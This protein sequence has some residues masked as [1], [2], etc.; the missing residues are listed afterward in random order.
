MAKRTNNSNNT[1]DFKI[2]SVIILK[3]S[4]PKFLKTLRPGSYSFY[5]KGVSSDFFAHN[6]NISA[7]VGKNGAGKSSL[8]DII[9][10]MINNF[11]A[12]LVGNSMKR[13]NSDVIYYIP[14]IY[15]EL[16]YQ[17]GDKKGVLY[18]YGNVV[19]LSFGES[20]YLLSDREQ[21]KNSRFDDFVDCY[22]PTASKRREIA[23]CF[24]Y[25]VV[26]NYALQAF[27]SSD[28]QDEMANKFET[29]DNIGFAFSGN[30]MNSLFHKNDGYASPI[31]LNPNRNEGVIDMKTETSLTRSR[32][33]AIIIETEKKNRTLIDGYRL[34]H[35]DFKFNPYRILLKLP[36]RIRKEDFIAFENVFRKYYGTRNSIVRCVLHNYGIKMNKTSSLFVWA[37]IYLVYNTLSIPSKY[38]NYAKYAFFG[39]KDVMDAKLPNAGDRAD[40]RNLVNEILDD[41]SHITTKIR[42]TLFFLKKINE[43]NMN[44]EAFD[45]TYYERWLGKE[46]ADSSLEAT[47]ELLPPPIFDSEIYLSRQNN[48]KE[49]PFYKLSSGERQFLFMIS[50]IIYHVMNIKSVPISRMAYR[51]LNI[52]LDEV[53]V[54]FHPEYQRTFIY[55]LLN[56]IE[57]LHLNTYCGFNII[58]TTHSP[59]L[60]SDIPQSNVLYLENGE[61]VD[62]SKMQ[63]PFAAN[64]ND[65]LYQS[66]FL[67]NGFMGEFAKQKIIKMI[68]EINNNKL[69][70][71]EAHELVDLV[72]EPILK[73]RLQDLIEE[74]LQ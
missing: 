1:G 37:C 9:F 38:S 74:S 71:Q 20:R 64:V 45:Y 29:D 70:V 12:Y 48:Q 32:L 46:K 2:L 52:V 3:E 18:N 41:K 30:W 23:R 68:N 7:I 56:I 73:E 65:I 26:M 44:D 63:N 21:M 31:V 33:V 24:F 59:F 58:I 40:L 47:M 36:E 17:M 51:Y 25:T 66:F 28:Y 5:D 67:S 61:V 72:G 22:K 15:S 53:E 62:K 50:S 6:V 8:L 42:Q 55:N 49:I 57:R 35:I 60:L 54:C 14:G 13:K 39:D 43:K 16:H 69:D 27:N 34:H 11:S 10:R 4:N 19:A